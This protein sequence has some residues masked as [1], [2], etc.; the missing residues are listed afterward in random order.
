MRL[1]HSDAKS[2]ARNAGG[3]PHGCT[4]GPPSRASVRTGNVCQCAHRYCLPNFTGCS[5]GRT[6]G[7]GAGGFSAVH[8]FV[9]G[10]AGAARL[11][12]GAARCTASV[13]VGTSS[14]SAE[15]HVAPQRLCECVARGQRVGERCGTFISGNDAAHLLLGMIRVNEQSPHISRER[16]LHR[17]AGRPAWPAR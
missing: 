12:V 6:G 15:F 14:H 9:A 2:R 1:M 5:E 13:Y 17:P 7:A 11:R 10:H 16:G 3:G 8:A 4:E